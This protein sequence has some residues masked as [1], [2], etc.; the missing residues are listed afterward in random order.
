LRFVSS[1]TA[2][3]LH[4]ILGELT[5]VKLFYVIILNVNNRNINTTHNWKVMPKTFA[6]TRSLGKSDSVLNAHSVG[7]NDSF[8]LSKD[9]CTPRD[10]SLS[11]FNRWGDLI[12]SADNTIREWRGECES[13]DCPE[14]V[15]YFQTIYADINGKLTQ[16]AGYIQLIR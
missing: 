12:Y 6:A 9:N 4:V 14:G 8:D 10:F 5:F 13:K 1:P 3:T 16:H 2:E 7:L 11:I 15:Y